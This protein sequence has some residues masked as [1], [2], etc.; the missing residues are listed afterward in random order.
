MDTRLVDP[1]GVAAVETELLPDAGDDRTDDLDL[2]CVQ[3]PTQPERYRDAGVYRSPGRGV[4]SGSHQ[5]S[6]AGAIVS[7][8]ENV[9]AR[10]ARPP[11]TLKGSPY[12]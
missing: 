8:D 3:H 1:H 6:S 9:F 5:T 11:V 7:R 4:E 2:E 10:R 12:A